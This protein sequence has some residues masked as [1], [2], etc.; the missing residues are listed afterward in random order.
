M[1]INHQKELLYLTNAFHQL[2]K[3]NLLITFL[4]TWKDE[5][6]ARASDNVPFEYFAKPQIYI[7]SFNAIEYRHRSRCRYTIIATTRL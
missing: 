6:V 7:R 4:S 3:R 5:K 1:Y 2:T